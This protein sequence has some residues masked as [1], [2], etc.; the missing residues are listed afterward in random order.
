MHVVF[1]VS[2]VA[3]S[4]DFY[5]RVFAW[6]RNERIDFAEYVELH[7]PDGG[8][9]GLCE[10]PTYVRLVGAEAVE[11]NG[12]V[13]PAY[14]YVR[15]PDPEAAAVRIET[16]GGRQLAPFQARSWGEEAAWFAD[17]DGNVVALAPSSAV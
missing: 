11:P 4:V 10:R 2:D 6:P 15:V 17:P 5:E 9:L 13:S 14:L 8:T 12:G 3:R 16:A 1:A 7:P